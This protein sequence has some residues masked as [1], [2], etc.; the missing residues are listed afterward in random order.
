MQVSVSDGVYQLNGIPISQP[1]SLGLGTYYFSNISSAH[2]M[3]WM[4]GSNGATDWTLKDGTQPIT[5]VRIE[6]AIMK[7]YFEGDAKLHVYR[8]F[9]GGYFNCWNHGDMSSGTLGLSA[10]VFNSDCPYAPPAP[11]PENGGGGGGGEP[12]FFPPPSPPPP[13]HPPPS[14][15][16]TPAMRKKGLLMSNGMTSVHFNELDG[17]GTWVYN[18][19]PR[20]MSQDQVDFVN[21]NNLDYMLMLNGAYIPIEIDS[22]IFGWPLAQGT[23]RRCYLWNEALPTNPNNQYYG[24]SLCELN[25]MLSVINATLKVVMSP[26]TKLAMFNEPYPGA[27]Y[28]QNA[29]LSARAY[30]DF[31]EP[32]ARV[33]GLKIISATTQAKS[34]TLGWDAEFLRACVDIGCDLELMNGWS[35]HLYNLKES[36]WQSSYAFP[37]GSFYTDRITEFANGYKSKSGAWF[38]TLFKRMP[39]YI[40]EMG[41][42]QEKE[43][44]YGPPDNTGTC[45]RLT[46]QFGNESLCNGEP[47]CGWG[48]GGLNWLLDD[49]QTNVAGALIWPSYYS[50]TGHN[51]DG[52]R[53]GRLVYHD[54]SLSPVGRAF[55]AAPDN[56]WAVDCHDVKAP[57]PPPSPPP[58]TP[59]TPPPNVVNIDFGFA[60]VV[61]CAGTSITVHWNGYHNIQEHTS[62]SCSSG[63]LAVHSDYKSAGHVETFTDLGAD[64]GQTRHF[65]CGLHCN[66][67]SSRFEVSCP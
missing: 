40:T 61:A 26:V 58:P 44:A 62:S 36:K 47:R 34:K 63:I 31:F 6:N 59:P 38:E 60:Q 57:L 52:G 15:P 27:A 50:P 9:Y 18:Y 54:G 43:T 56:G 3:T 2:P 13:H 12:T 45:L 28:E 29:T 19:N 49:A 46:G 39:L 20:P 7:Y 10:F 1:Y 21:R 48:R 30:K 67:A 33:F 22:F 65:A 14:S 16:M 53:S 23:N 55:I 24:S 32:A 41:A 51:Q 5:R 8:D 35:I 11:P 25:D 4:Q 17:I 66:T 64:P 42:T 37:N